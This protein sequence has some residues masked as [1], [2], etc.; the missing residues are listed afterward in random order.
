METT[1]KEP[2]KRNRISGE[3]K[4]EI[5]QHIL[6]YPENKAE[7]LRKE[8]LYSSDLIRFERIIKEGAIKELKRS[9]PG[10][11]KKEADVDIEEYLRLKNELVQ[12]EKTLA[13]ITVEF[14]ILKK[15]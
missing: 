3:K 6:Q 8:G 13:D 15:K 14:M 11:K 1:H 5:Y 10:R 2:R 7:I 12:K 4:F 9:K